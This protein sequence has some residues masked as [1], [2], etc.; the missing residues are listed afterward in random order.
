MALQKAFQMLTA[1]GI[2]IAF[3]VFNFA[4]VYVSTW[5]RF[6]GKNPLKGIMAKRAA[7]K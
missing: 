6:K 3:I 2:F 5:I 4:V 7:K 1:T